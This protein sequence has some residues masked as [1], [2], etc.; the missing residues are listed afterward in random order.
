MHLSGGEQQRVAIARALVVDPRVI[1][2]DEPTGNLDTKT[3]ADVFE[4]LAGLATSHGATVVV[5]THDAELAT[6]VP[7]RLV[8]RDGRLVDSAVTSTPPGRLAGG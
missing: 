1:L 5:A 6:R 7:T 4:L 8:M 3:G 2:A